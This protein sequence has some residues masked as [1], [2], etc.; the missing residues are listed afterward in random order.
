MKCGCRHMK[1]LASLEMKC[2][3]HEAK[4]SLCVRRN[5][6]CPKDTSCRRRFMFLKER[7]ILKKPEIDCNQFQAFSVV[8]AERGMRNPPKERILI[9]CENIF[10]CLLF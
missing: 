2:L 1:Y 5:A 8:E 4:R 6:S 7:F 3:Q 10:I 9:I